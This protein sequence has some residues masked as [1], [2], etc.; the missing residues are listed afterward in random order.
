V[1]LDI[2]DLPP[3]DHLSVSITCASDQPLSPP[4]SANSQN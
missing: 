1:L 4:G 3:V 2:G